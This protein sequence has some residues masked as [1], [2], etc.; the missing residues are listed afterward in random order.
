MSATTL[1]DAEQARLAGDLDAAMAA[2]RG[3]LAGLPDD[4]AALNLIA[5]IAADRGQIEEGLA[6]AARAARA[7]S[8]AAGP[9][10]TMGRLFEMQQRLG[11]AEASYRRAID[12]APRD[13]RAHNNL[14]VVLQMQG[15]AADALACYRAAVELA[16]DLPEANQNYASIARDPAALERAVR[17]FRA[18]TETNPEDAAAY[19]SA[20]NALRELGRHDESLAAY[21]R[22]IALQPDFAE[23][24]FNRS[25]VLLQTA[26]YAR[27]WPEYEWRLKTPTHG[28]SAARFA[29]PMW[30]GRETARTVLVHAE[31]G[32]GDTIQFARFAPLAAARCGAL[33]LEVQPEVFPVLTIMKG[34]PRIV[35]R[36]DPL[37][38][39]EMHAPLLSLPALLGTTIESIPWDGPYIQAPHERVMAW[40][41]AFAKRR[42]HFNV[43]L[44]WAGRP[45]HWDDLNRS[46]PLARLS[47]LARVPDVSFFSLQ[48]G[49]AAEEA[50]HPPSGMELLD[51]TSLIRDFADTAALV[52]FLDLVV[53]VD[54]SVA[55]LAGAM[56]VPTWVLLAHA[57]D[58]R[59]H[60]ARE[61]SPWYPSTKLFRQPTDGDWGGAVERMA[62]GLERAAAAKPR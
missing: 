22:A 19:N 49:P 16:P 54:T 8:R 35:V 33:V 14:G 50:K 57:P 9:H 6:W 39:F 27:G 4:P 21:D 12:L 47:P 58:W 51:L 61:D 17:G 55:H 60:L 41:R 43:G 37:P 45:Q 10:Y 20:A 31:Q 15:R 3:V 38:P 59:W 56:G 24:R 25:M 11:E 2:C 1:R 48:L 5:A 34:A 7:D 40:R 46:V 13:A 28:G 52:S 62:A 42:R 30:H 23:A 53:T 29:Q 44:V 26:D 32:L 36:G 18:R